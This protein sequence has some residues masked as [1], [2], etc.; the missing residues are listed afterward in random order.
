MDLTGHPNILGTY[1]HGYNE[2]DLVIFVFTR[3]FG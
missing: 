3:S 1:M 2:K